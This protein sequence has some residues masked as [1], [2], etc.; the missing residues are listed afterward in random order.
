MASLN[1]SQQL[2]LPFPSNGPSLAFIQGESNRA[3]IAILNQW[4]ERFCDGTQPGPPVILLRGAA[5][6]GKSRLLLEFMTRRGGS[7][8]TPDTKGRLFPSRD[9]TPLAV[10]D[11]HRA[12]AED[13]FSIFN[14]CVAERRALI[15]CGAGRP[16]SWGTAFG[17]DLV[18]LRSRLSGVAIAS[19][20]PPDPAMV[21]EALLSGL[22]SLGYAADRSEVEHAAEQLRR[23]FSAVE[24]IL[25]D[26]AM[27]GGKPTA[28]RALLHAAIKDNP[29]QVL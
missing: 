8:I 27:R 28:V 29:D 7:I 5:G 26:I 20:D 24:T 16:V 22:S 19:L 15:L 21:A 9:G 14:E 1:F 10:D 2:K 12:G 11:V 23:R 25:A 17:E 6:A 18:D 4:W 13:L 3:A